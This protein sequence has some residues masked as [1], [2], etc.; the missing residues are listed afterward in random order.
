MK[1][2][3]LKKISRFLE[4]YFKSNWI[5]AKQMQSNQVWAGIII[6]RSN[7]LDIIY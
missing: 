2:K 5:Y 3:L 4:K 7:C 6:I 1:M